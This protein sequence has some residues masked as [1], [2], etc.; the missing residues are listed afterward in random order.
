MLSDHFN[1]EFGAGFWG[2][3][4]TYT[5]YSCPR[6]G[7]KIEEG[8]KWFICPNEAIVSIVYVF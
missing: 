1:L 6:C 3:Y 2:G 4:K 8:K 7:R 5:V